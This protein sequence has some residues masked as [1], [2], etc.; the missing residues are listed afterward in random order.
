MTIRNHRPHF[1]YVRA[2]VLI[3]TFM[4]AVAAVAVPFY[5]VSSKAMEGAGASLPIVPSSPNTAKA[6]NVPGWT[7]TLNMPVVGETIAI[8][9]ADCTTPKTE[10]NLGEVI[11]AVT[12]GVDLTTVP[13]NYY[14]NWHSPSNGITNGP[15]ITTNPQ[16]FLFTLPTTPS[17]N[18]GTWKANIG[19]V[20]PAES[21]II[22][23]PPNFNVGDAPAYL[24]LRFRL[25]DS[26]DPIQ[27][28]GYGLGGLRQSNG[29]P[30]KSI[31][32]LV[33]R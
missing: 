24:N 8:Y 12:D 11:C 9:G 18:L 32:P 19:R 27:P 21:S 30:G 25:Y 31:P 16:S 23:S 1:T 7:S 20:T 15:T 13:G 26:E 3:C 4:I 2:L 10:F 6:M 22:G 17:G 14:V 28:P 5:S 29:L 33:Q